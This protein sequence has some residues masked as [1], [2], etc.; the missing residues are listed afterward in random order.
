MTMNINVACG[1][2]QIDNKTGKCKTCGFYGIPH[3]RN[4]KYR[5]KVDRRLRDNGY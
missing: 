2:Y 3:L 1:D 4:P 5:A